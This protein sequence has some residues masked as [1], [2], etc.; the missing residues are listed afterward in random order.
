MNLMSLGYTD[1]LRA[2]I[3]YR[4]LGG[5][6]VE[7]LDRFAASAGTRARCQ[8]EHQ[9]ASVHAQ[10]LEPARLHPVV[11]RQELLRPRRTGLASRTVAAVR[12]RPGRHAAEP[13]DRGQP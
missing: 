5:A 10:G 7:R 1:I 4:Y 8:E 11:R 12:G 9:P 13:A 2:T 6:S 3:R